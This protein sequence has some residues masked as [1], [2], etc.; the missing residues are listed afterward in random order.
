[1][2]V[3]HAHNRT[4]TVQ[5]ANIQTKRFYIEEEDRWVKLKVSTRAIRTITKIGLKKFAAKHGVSMKSLLK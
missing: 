5:Q 2:K 4:K 3:S 1:M